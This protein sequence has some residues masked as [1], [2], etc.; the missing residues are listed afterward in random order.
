MSDP[1]RPDDLVFPKLK[2]AGKKMPKEEFICEEKLDG[3]S[4]M[5]IKGGAWGRRISEVTGHRENKWDQLPWWIQQKAQPEVLVHGEL[6]VTGGVA[7]DV[8]SA[9]KEGRETDW[10]GEL[11]QRLQFVAYNLPYHDGGPIEHRAKLKD[12]DF[13]V[14][15]VLML[16]DFEA[17]HWALT[18]H[19]KQFST[20]TMLGIV[21]EWL[22]EIAKRE[23]IEGWVLK[24][25]YT[26]APWWKLRVTWTYDC[27]VMGTK[28][29]TGMNFG[30]VGSLLVGMF[31]KV[32]ETEPI[33]LLEEV[34]SV[35]G[36]TEAERDWMTE[37]R[38]ELEGRVCEVEANGVCSRGRLHHPR[39]VRWREDK[40]A[41]ECTS[42]QLETKR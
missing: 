17:G 36:M 6:Y 34:A 30:D 25:I 5:L 15:R 22:I 11:A 20:P 8:K 40:P 26:A 2:K 24:E 13:D 38:D 37:H 28:D 42:E 4:L 14:P 32:S 12:M 3:E 19:W 39:F 23:K 7:S 35:G 18:Q 41:N 29:G 27:V 31:T 9:M 1:L 21:P 16:R 10:K 33:A